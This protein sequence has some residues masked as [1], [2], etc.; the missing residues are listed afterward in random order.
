MI[1]ESKSIET[2]LEVA[3]LRGPG[4]KDL[5]KHLPELQSITSIPS[6]LELYVDDPGRYDEAI[7]LLEYVGGLNDR[8]SEQLPIIKTIYTQ[9]RK[10]HENL[11]TN[12][13]NRLDDLKESSQ[14][15]LKELINQIIRCGTLTSRDLRLRFLQARDYW[16]N[17]ECEAK[18]DSFDELI[19]FFCR[20]LPKIFEEYKSLFSDPT[21]LANSKL[22]AMHASSN[23]LAREDGAI[24]NSWL[25]LKT[26]T[27]ILSLE[28]HLKSLEHSKAL[29]PTMIGDTM[30]KCFKLTNWLASIG[31]DFSSQLKPLFLRTITNEIK[32]SIETATVRFES[33][34]TRIISKSI[35]SLLLPADDEILRISRMKPEEQ[36]PKSMNHYPVFKIYCLHIIDSMRWVQAMNGLLSPISLCQDVYAAMNASLTRVMNAVAVV[37]N[38]DNNSNHPILSKIA[39][40]FLTEVLPFMTN[41]CDQ[42]FPEKIVLSALGLSKTE[43]KN[44]CANEPER[45]RNFRLDLMQIG[46]SLR[47][48]MPALMQAIGR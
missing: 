39:I 9:T 13:C 2:N 7:E 42:I 44:I 17:N 4:Y 11:V 3:F 45:V 34:F 19:S 1:E 18:A 12:L 21:S 5:C 29:T 15:E 20:G 48:L 31:F 22:M 25:L 32:F 14:E 47:V 23:S 10:H 36:A 16:F 6:K 33:D 43:F 30:Q 8:Y 24:I 41:Y 28:M 26:S 46:H 35:E 27:F 38:M 37:L 40:S